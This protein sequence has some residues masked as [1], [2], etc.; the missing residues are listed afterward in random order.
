MTR[1]NL[2]GSAEA[3]AS[4]ERALDLPQRFRTSPARG[5][6]LR[7]EPMLDWLLFTREGR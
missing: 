5:G 6:E 4:T 2:C 7:Q 3:M 1:T